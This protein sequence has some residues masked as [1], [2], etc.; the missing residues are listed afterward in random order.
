L[1]FEEDD[2]REVK[3]AKKIDLFDSAKSEEERLEALDE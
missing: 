3:R 1:P 2:I